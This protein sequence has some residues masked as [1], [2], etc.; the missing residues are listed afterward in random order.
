[1]NDIIRE[2]G[3]DHNVIADHKKEKEQGPQR[4]AEVIDDSAFMQPDDV[5]PEEP[6]SDEIGER[7]RIRCNGGDA[8]T[9]T[10]EAIATLAAEKRPFKAVYVRSQMLVRVVR[11]EG[12]AEP[13]ARGIRRAAGTSMLVPVTTDWM[14]LHLGRL[15]DWYS[16]RRDRAGNP[17]ETIRD[18]PERIARAVMADNPW[19]GVPLL[20]G[21]VNAP[22]V[23]GDGSVL[24][25][26]GYDRKSGLLFDPDRTKF[27]K[28]PHRPTKADA[29][30]A[31]DILRRP[32]REFP[33]VGKD[34]ERV[35]MNEAV[36]L[37][38]VITA[39]VRK[40]LTI[41]PMFVFDAPTPSSGKTLLASVPSYVAT[42]R[43]PLL[44]AP[45]PDP[46]AERKALFAAL[47]E[48]PSCIVIDN[49]E[50]EFGSTVL[51]AI[52]TTEEYSERMLGQS[53]NVKVPTNAM[54]AATGNN[55]TIKGDLGARTLICRIDPRTEDPDTRTFS[56]DLHKWL[57][58]HRAKLAAAAITIVK[59][60][61]LARPKID[62]PN[63][64]RFHEWQQLCRFPLMWL[65]CED[66]CLSRERIREENPEIADLRN[67]LQSW[68][69][70]FGNAPVSVSAAIEECERGV[71]NSDEH[72]QNKVALLDAMR[73]VG[74][75]GNF[76]SNRRVG[77][78]IAARRMRIIDG[79]Y[80]DKDGL[81]DGI[82]RWR[83]RHE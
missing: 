5:L 27:P 67:L 51:N 47:I 68:F 2:L 29:M 13:D 23:L 19:P 20:S 11:Y 52:L 3:Y 46:E 83:V 30:R 39:L 76:V 56:L 82:V 35:C 81:Y 25:T 16:V 71:N 54:F 14:T 10:R 55:M 64:G 8:A 33:F 45:N 69:A 17:V 59:A 32:F 48:S 28:I 79:Y 72:D 34:S 77:R 50:G 65:G 9:A 57:P 31:L 63:Y 40:G 53:R 18:C 4:D 12:K 58:M 37:S 70:V 24:Q 62:A 43:P 44:M 6:E 61:L 66:P 15:A 7:P 60:F 26:P 41:A 80:F 36:A 75:R 42:G 1:M 38:S 74:A 49:V 21:V 78:F 73:V 22:T